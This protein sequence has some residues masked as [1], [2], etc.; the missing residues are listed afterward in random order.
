MQ[1]PNNCVLTELLHF[2]QR[3]PTHPHTH[4]VS[5]EQIIHAN[6][7]VQTITPRLESESGEE[8]V[9]F[10]PL[11][12]ILS[13]TTTTKSVNWFKFYSA[14]LNWLDLFSEWLGTV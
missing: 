1:I 14:Q 4:T 11:A 7:C 8:K 2:V 3:P 13:T 9:S 10:E 6:L 12:K 5:L